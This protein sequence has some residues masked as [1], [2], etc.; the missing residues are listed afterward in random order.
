MNEIKIDKI[1]RSKRSTVSIQ[2]NEDN[3]LVVRAPSLV[4][5]YSEKWFNL[6]NFLVGAGFRQFIS[7]NTYSYIEVLWNLNEN[8]NSVYY[9][10]VIRAGVSY[11]F[12]NKKRYNKSDLE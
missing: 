6:D 5:P 4:Y 10:P 8:I 7:Y 11:A 3:K 2:I 9:S 1:I 12:P